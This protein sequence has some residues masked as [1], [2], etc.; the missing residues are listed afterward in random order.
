MKPKIIMFVHDLQDARGDV[1]KFLDKVAATGCHDLHLM[2]FRAAPGACK[3]GA[4]VMPYNMVGEW[5]HPTSGMTFP[6]YR[7][8]KNWYKPYF[9]KLRAVLTELKRREIRPWISVHDIRL[10]DKT[11]KYWHPFYCSE[12]ALGPNTPGGVWGEPD[13]PWGMYPYHRNFIRLLAQRVYEVCDDPAWEV[14]NEFN[15]PPFQSDDYM[16]EAH[17]EL[18]DVLDSIPGGVPEKWTSGTT[19]AYRNAQLYSAHGVVRPEKVKPVEGIDNQAIIISGD[20]GFD[21]DGRYDKKA[22]K[23][24][25]GASPAQATAIVKRIKELKMYGYEVLDRGL[26]L[27]DTDVSNLDDFDHAT[28]AAAVKEAGRA[29]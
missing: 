4:T 14:C 1:P 5:T 29:R 27:K 12:E 16:V 15:T 20:G 19:G 13:K 6:L 22:G 21:G 10:R 24:R 3:Q 23:I 8:T 25:R 18:S 11:G 28:L 26:W 9:K 2:V 7:L 17:G